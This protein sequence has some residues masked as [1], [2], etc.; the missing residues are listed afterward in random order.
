MGGSSSKRKVAKLSDDEDDDDGQEEELLRK[1]EDDDDDGDEKGVNDRK[2]K[3][4]DTSIRSISWTHACCLFYIPFFWIFV[5]FG[6]TLTYAGLL[7]GEGGKC[8]VNGTFVTLQPSAND[9]C[10]A[11]LSGVVSYNVPASPYYF[12]FS[13]WHCMISFFCFFYYDTYWD[14]IRRFYN[15]FK[16]LT[17][18]VS[19][20]MLAFNAVLYAANTELEFAIFLAISQL[21]YVLAVAREEYQCSLAGSD[22]NPTSLSRRFEPSDIEEPS[23][24]DF[25]MFG[26]TRRVSDNGLLYMY[27]G[28]GCCAC[29]SLD[30]F[31][32]QNVE[33]KK[34][35]GWRGWLPFVFCCSQIIL[36]SVYVGLYE[37]V[38]GPA[39]ETYVYMVVTFFILINVLTWTGRMGPNA[40]IWSEILSLFVFNAVGTALASSLIARCYD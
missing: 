34:A 12:V 35:Y 16:Y 38:I 7:G 14:G 21:V 32:T 11:T 23:T 24:A 4:R 25:L 19:L 31:Q 40:F 36:W 22:G 17:Y 37:N 9:T 3:K 13:L 28:A 30:A 10:N 5:I 27:K 8:E 18:A 39:Q 1:D 6:S 15:P 26:L 2:V 20:P 29:K 33:F